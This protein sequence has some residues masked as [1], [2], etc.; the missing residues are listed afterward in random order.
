MH[1][2]RSISSTVETEREVFHILEVTLC[3]LKLEE[4]D[5]KGV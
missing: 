4:K 5:C 3:S 1:G 2:K